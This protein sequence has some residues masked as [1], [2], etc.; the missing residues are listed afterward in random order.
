M[1]AVEICSS[2]RIVTGWPLNGVA[3]ERYALDIGFKDFHDIR[4]PD[5][6]SHLSG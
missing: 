1:V 4:F 2:A 3:F 5:I 6:G